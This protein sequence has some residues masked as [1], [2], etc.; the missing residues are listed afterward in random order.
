MPDH[1]HL[2]LSG[3]SDTADAMNAVIAFPQ[4]PSDKQ[5]TG[6][7]LSK[8]FRDVRW[9]KDFYDHVLR[10]PDEVEVQVK[11]ILANPVRKHIVED[12]KDYEFKGS[13]VY[14]FEEW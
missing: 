12:W 3:K 8:K 2:L 1:C 10:D 6:Y 11:Y 5:R 14:D 9:Q 13:T 4:D 7:W